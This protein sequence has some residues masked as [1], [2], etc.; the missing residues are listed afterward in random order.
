[1]NRAKG[2]A[3]I[4]LFAPFDPVYGSYWIEGLRHV[5]TIELHP[6]PAPLPPS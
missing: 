4:R 5:G 1:M 3:R 2:S 6:L